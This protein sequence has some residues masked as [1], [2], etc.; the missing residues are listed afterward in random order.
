[1]PLPTDYQ[2]TGPGTTKLPYPALTFLTTEDPFLGTSTPGIPDGPFNRELHKLLRNDSALANLFVGYLGRTYGV[3]AEVAPD[4]AP[5]P[6]QNA[7]VSPLDFSVHAVYYSNFEVHYTFNATSGLWVEMAR[8]ERTFSVFTRHLKTVTV[9]LEDG[10][11]NITVTLPTTDSDDNDFAFTIEHL[12]TFYILNL[13]DEA[14]LISVLPGILASET[15]L[16]VVASAP[17]IEGSNYQLVL[18][19][20]HIDIS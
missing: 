12:K 7:P 1:M 3:L 8:I 14:P 13:D 5:Q 4:E 11:D 10:E 6:P 20:E 9:A 16:R 2:A 17:P 15:V 19:F 18:V